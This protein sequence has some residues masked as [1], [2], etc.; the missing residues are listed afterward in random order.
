MTSYLTLSSIPT[1]ISV[2]STISISILNFTHSSLLS[3]INC[4]HQYPWKKL[5]TFVQYFFSVFLTSV[6]LGNPPNPPN[7]LNSWQLS[8]SSPSLYIIAAVGLARVTQT[9]EESIAAVKV[10]QRCS[11]D[12]LIQ[13]AHLQIRFVNRC[14]PNDPADVTVR[15]NVV[16]SE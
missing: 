7:P 14:I 6:S 1:S 15:S 3:R 16:M 13:S 2:L 8:C 11:R 12:T 5:H 4:S 9:V 10:E